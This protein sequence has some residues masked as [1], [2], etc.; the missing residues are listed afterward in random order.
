MGGSGTLRQSSGSDHQDVV[1]ERTPLL[2]AGHG[3]IYESNT[4]PDSAVVENDDFD[5]TDIDPNEFD[6]L[7]SRAQSIN[8]GLG[9]EAESQETAML[10]GP[11]RYS[12]V[13]GSR[14][15]SHVRRKKSFASTISSNYEVIEEGS[16]DEDAE[17]IPKSPFLAGA[18]VRTFWLIFGGIMITYF[19]ACF[20]STIMVSSHPVIT[21]YF[22]SSNSASWLSTAFLLTSTSFQPLFGRLS[23][24][25]GRK[26]PYVLTMG[27]FLIA[28]IWCAVAQSMTS[29]II[30][31]A[32]CGLGAGG[33]MAMGSIITS[34]LVPI[35][36][37][38]AYQSYLNIVFGAGSAAGAALGGAIADSLGWRW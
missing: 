32:F 34:D 25:I 12:S 18:S 30:A 26:P 2:A 35:E 31:R 8:G 37:R 14:A 6:N 24:T 29:F 28:T 27:I 19:V 36:I 1:D 23:D 21:S 22:E 4:L 9:I 20:D 15:S 7:L 10:R 5:G 13:N 38:G 11:R 16:S 33:M 17:S 3:N